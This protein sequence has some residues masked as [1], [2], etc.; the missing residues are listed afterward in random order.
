MAMTSDSSSVVAISD[1][2]G[3]MRCAIIVVTG[4]LVKI[5][6]PRSP[7]RTCHS[8]SPKRTTKGRSSPSDAR[9]R[10]TSAGVA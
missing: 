5:E 8:Q 9:M 7:C 10:S 3:S 4:R 1:S 2:V 6:M